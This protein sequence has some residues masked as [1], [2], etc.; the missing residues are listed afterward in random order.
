MGTTPGFLVLIA[1]LSSLSCSVLPRATD[2]FQSSAAN[3]VFISVLQHT[4]RETDLEAEP[5]FTGNAVRFFS[6]PHCSLHP[7]TS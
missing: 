3:L 1:L 6:L 7:N 2:H 4:Q 5:H